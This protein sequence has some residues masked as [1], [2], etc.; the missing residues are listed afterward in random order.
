MSSRKIVVKLPSSRQNYS[1]WAIII[2][3]LDELIALENH[4]LASYSLYVFMYT[5][6][7]NHLTGSS[8]SGLDAGRPVVPGM[9]ELKLD[10]LVSP[11]RAGGEVYC[12]ILNKLNVH[13]EGILQRAMELRREAL[14]EYYSSQWARYASLAK[15]LGNICV[16]ISTHWV[17]STMGGRDD[18]YSVPVLAITRWKSVFVDGLQRADQKLTNALLSL[19]A[20]QRSGESI[21]SELLKSILASLA[22]LGRSGGHGET[23]TLDVYEEV[24][25]TPFLDDAREYY[26]Q[27]AK[28]IAQ[29]PS[30]ACQKAV[31]VGI[32]GNIQKVEEIGR[33]KVES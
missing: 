21:N 13:L 8:R 29:G 26:R 4:K 24:F 28:F 9:A 6:V 15:L 17:K 12:T 10:A 19:I 32:S 27:C 5:A 18:I 1:S 22:T 33:L 16:H 2:R 3:C 23:E 20:S 11:G 31:G 25:E 14:L 30:E 7:L